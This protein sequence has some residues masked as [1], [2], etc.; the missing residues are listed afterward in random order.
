MSRLSARALEVANTSQGGVHVVPHASGVEEV[1]DV[2]PILDWNKAA[3]EV[4]NNRK[5]N[6]R[7]QA[8]IPNV[9]L[10]RWFHEELDRGNVHLKMFGKEFDEIIQRKLKD[11][12]NAWMLASPTGTAYKQGYSL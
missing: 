7:H 6:W 11:P 3:Q 2:E 12:E 9:I 1:Q 4:A 8:R 10:N 5:A